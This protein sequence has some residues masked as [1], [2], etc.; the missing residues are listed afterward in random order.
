[1]FKAKMKLHASTPFAEWSARYDKTWEETADGLCSIG[2]AVMLTNV[3]ASLGY[4]EKAM[5][6]DV[7]SAK[8][9]MYYAFGLYKQK[10]SLPKAIEV[11]R[12][13]VQRDPENPRAQYVLGIIYMQTG[14]LPKSIPHLEKAVTGDPNFAM[15]WYHLGLAN[16]TAG[17]RE[18]SIVAFRRAVACQPDLGWAWLKLGWLLLNQ[19]TDVEATIVFENAVRLKPEKLN[20][21]AGL[22]HALYRIGSFR[23]AIA[24]YRK[25]WQLGGG[26]GYSVVM[27]YGWSCMHAGRWEETA[28][29]WAR[30]VSMKPESSY[31]LT[32]TAW[33][34]LGS[35]RLS[36]AQE[37][38]DLATELWNRFEQPWCGRGWIAYERGKFA[39]AL[40]EF[41]EANQRKSGYVDALYGAGLASRRLNHARKAR[42]YFEQTL[43]WAPNHA[44][45]RY[46]MGRLC[47]DGGD[48]VGALAHCD[49]LRDLDTGLAADLLRRIEK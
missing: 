29:I 40:T 42:E 10:R 45:T 49:V 17:R 11:A 26:D 18:A 39:Q 30:G 43:H 35:G 46:E 22:G 36:K 27:Y 4:F 33:G 20:S 14:E 38:F 16:S 2:L 23:R 44:G 48:S 8:A 24:S 9:R 5:E 6:Q 34:C 28:R 31:P 32:F 25:A 3:P 12:E 41:E 37:L 7:D 19:D 21:H 47:L 1:M 15:G 13:A